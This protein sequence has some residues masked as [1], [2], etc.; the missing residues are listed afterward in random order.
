MGDSHIIVIVFTAIGSFVAAIF[1][2]DG[3]Q[4][5]TRKKEI[6]QASASHEEFKK[7]EAEMNMM[8]REFEA[9]MAAER[10]KTSNIKVGVDMMLTM[11]EDIADP[12]YLV[13]ME[14]VRKI[15]NEPIVPLKKTTND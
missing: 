10:M 8:R 14:K 3:W 11:F 9:R 4:Y 15:I 2:K 7:L 1:G 13:I 6:E 12:K 5:L